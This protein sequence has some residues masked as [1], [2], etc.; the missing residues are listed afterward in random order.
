VKATV[1]YVGPV[2]D[3]LDD[4]RPIAPGETIEDLDLDLPHNKLLHDEGRLVVLDQKRERLTGKAL[5]DRAA[6]L[7]IEGRTDMSADQL[8]AAI[9]KKEAEEAD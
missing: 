3:T 1:T 5:S 9:A 4:G 7:D 6:E 2:A 8:R